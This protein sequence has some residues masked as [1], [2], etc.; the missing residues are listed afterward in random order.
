MYP[1]IRYAGRAPG[2][3]LNQLGAEGSIIEGPAPA[4]V[5]T[6]TT[7]DPRWGDYTNL[8]LDPV[9]DCIFW[10]VN[11]YMVADKIPEDTVAALSRWWKTRIASFKFDGCASPTAVAVRRFGAQWLGKH[12]AVTWRTASET[13]ILGFNVFRSIGAGPF[14]K[15]NRTLIAARGSS[16][17]GA[18]YRIADRAVRRAETYTYRLQVVSPGGKRT[19]YGIGSAAVR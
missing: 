16:A 18:K 6:A 9:N 13:E 17:G 15:L 5:A 3:P 2:D 19:W 11:E 12:V 10:H 1:S 4:R 14:R 8:T 7:G